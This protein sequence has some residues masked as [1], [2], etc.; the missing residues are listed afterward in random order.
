M[1]ARQ[2]V[3]GLSLLRHDEKLLRYVEWTLGRCSEVEQRRTDTIRNLLAL[4]LERNGTLRHKS[5][6]E[7]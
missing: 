6:P 3:S 1:V 4:A 5:F 7:P 2:A